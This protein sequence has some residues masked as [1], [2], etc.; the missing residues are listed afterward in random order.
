MLLTPCFNRYEWTKDGELFI[1]S[2]HVKK[3]PGVGTLTFVDP[4]EDDEGIYQ[5]SARNE[6]GK[7]VAYKT[8]LRAARKF[9]FIFICT[10]IFG[11]K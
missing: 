6:H 7:A 11:Y 5:C 8:I 9:I 3:T 2:P 10:F 4:G 1:P